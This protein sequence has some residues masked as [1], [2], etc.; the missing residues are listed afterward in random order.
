[1][2]SIVYGT[3]SNGRFTFERRKKMNKRLVLMMIAAFYVVAFAGAVFAQAPFAR[4][5]VVK[6]DGYLHE[7][8]TGAVLADTLIVVNNSNENKGM[9][10]WIEVFDKYGTLEGEQT[11]LN[12]GSELEENS[13][14]SSG[15]GWITLGMIVNRATQDPWGNAAGEN[16]SFRI[17]NHLGSTPPIIQVKQVIYSTVQ[18]FPGEAI[19][20]ADNIKMWSETPLGGHMGPGVCRVPKKMRWWDGGTM[21]DG[22]MM[23]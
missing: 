12:D 9:P 1:V 18:Q 16:F 15:Y 23:R 13:I 8:P 17:T 19:W 7:D 4:K 3:A 5:W 2:D 14:P 10:I 11:L 6:Y 21:W 20:Q 22:G